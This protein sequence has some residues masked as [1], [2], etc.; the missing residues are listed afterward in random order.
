[1]CMKY[2]CLYICVRVCMCICAYVWFCMG[3]H[4]GV[5]FVSIYVCT[6][7]MHMSM[8]VNICVLVC[9]YLCLWV[10]LHACVQVCACKCLGTCGITYCQSYICVCLWFHFV[11][12][13]KHR[14]SIFY[15]V[16][17]LC[18]KM[19][20][21]WG[22]SGDPGQCFWFLTSIESIQHNTMAHS[23]QF[24]GCSWELI[25]SSVAHKKIAQF[26]RG[27][28]L[29]ADRGTLLFCGTDQVLST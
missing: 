15:K 17:L 25:N 11:L 2:I 4:V 19:I 7:C 23:A 27:W 18:T 1:M 22:L 24:G 8:F 6:M 3:V 14:S 26:L 21:S 20:G 12:T 28:I 5:Y 9:V 10:I 16:L 13:Q 29:G